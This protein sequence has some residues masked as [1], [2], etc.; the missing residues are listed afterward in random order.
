MCVANFAGNTHEGFRLGLPW[1]GE[2]EEVLNT[3]AEQ[4][5]G[6]GVGNLGRVTATEGA[7][8]D[9]PASAE[10]TVPPLAVLFL[11]PAGSSAT[12]GTRTT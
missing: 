12:A 3:D 11:K 9:K 6:S 7:Y 2:W 1:A 8:N 5:G 10:L 4:F